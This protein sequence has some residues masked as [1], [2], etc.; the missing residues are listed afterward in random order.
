M[1]KRLF[2]YLALAFALTWI[3]V[4]VLLAM[5]YPYS[6]IAF[7][8]CLF[9]VMLMPAL[10]SILTRLVTKEGF[11]DLMLRPKFRG[12]LR[13][14]LA[15]WL[16][17]GV[18]ILAAAAL[19]FAVF[20]RTFDSSLSVLKMVF[21]KQLA[22]RSIGTIILMQMALGWLAAPFINFIPALGEELGWR[23]YMLPKLCALL[24]TKKAI[25]VSGI[26]WGLWHAPMI[27]AGHN[28]GTGYW[29]WPVTGILAMVVFSMAYGSFLAW[30]TLRSGSALP[31]ALAHGGLNGFASIG[32]YFCRGGAYS[33]F[34]GPVATG[35]VGGAPVLV[36]G[37]LFWRRSRSL[38]FAPAGESGSV[39]EDAGEDPDVE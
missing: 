34:V 18:L 31:A 12:H 35:I 11:K 24:G 39:S 32:V 27:A 38:S 3:P 7:F 13:Y 2:N 36:A 9:C 17:P 22:T 6:S 23:G 37:Y 33:P 20:P 1:K 21:I 16:L 19:Y 14:Y 29:G 30:L 28:Y 5:G 25:P 4:F 8:V 15:G 26:I 10:S